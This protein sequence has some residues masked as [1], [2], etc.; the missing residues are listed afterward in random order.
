MSAPNTRTNK[1]LWDYY[2]AAALPAVIS[3]VMQGTALDAFGRRGVQ[4]TERHITKQAAEFA[5]AMLAE[6]ANRMEAES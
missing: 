1:Q 6:R 2:A 3:A 4:I 5:D